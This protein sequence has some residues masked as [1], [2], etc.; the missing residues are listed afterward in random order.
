LEWGFKTI[1]KTRTLT[2]SGNKINEIPS[3]LSNLVNLERVSLTNNNINKIPT[4]IS[5]L[6]KLKSFS[7]KR[8]PLTFP[9]NSIIKGGFE[10]MMIYLG[11]EH[12]NN[13]SDTSVFD[14]KMPG[15]LKTSFKQYLIYFSEFVSFSKGI[16]IYFEVYNSEMGLKIEIKQKTQNSQIASYF[17]EYLSFIKKKLDEIKPIYE[18]ST[19]ELIQEINL[20]QLK[21]QVSNLQSSI[22][23]KEIE[24]KLLSESVDRLTNIILNEKNKEINLSISNINNLSNS[25]NL[26][27]KYE[28]EPNTKSILG[29]KSELNSLKNQIEKNQDYDYKFRIELLQ[30]LVDL[31]NEIN[32]GKISKP[33]FDK[34]LERGAKVGTVGNFLINL[35]KILNEN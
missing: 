6:P 9:S 7:I 16:E 30:D 11:K 17:R 3:F 27:I 12:I 23:M 21:R 18:I 32:S 8:N 31:E 14:L 29:L 25:N 2:L 13:M 5:L 15:I 1:S 22:Q 10:I 26:D 34:L 19:T 20:I 28:V 33:I 4:E 24:N 35:I